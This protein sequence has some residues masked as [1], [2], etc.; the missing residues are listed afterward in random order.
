MKGEPLSENLLLAARA[1]DCLTLCGAG[2]F[3]QFEYATPEEAVEDR[4]RLGIRRGFLV[5]MAAEALSPLDAA[6]S[7]TAFCQS[8]PVRASF[9]RS[10]RCSPMS[11]FPR[12]R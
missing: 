4:A 8:A 1:I 5:S 10:L 12:V 9:F 6:K 11:F 7:L 3:N 2:R